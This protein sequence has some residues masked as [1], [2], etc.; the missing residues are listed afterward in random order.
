MDL[1]EADRCFHS[2]LYNAF[3]ALARRVVHSICADKGAY[4]ARDLYIQIEDLGG[5]GLLESCR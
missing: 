5:R 4:E 2:K 1:L 3:G